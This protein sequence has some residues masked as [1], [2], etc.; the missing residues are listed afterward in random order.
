MSEKEVTTY[1]DTLSPA[2]AALWFIEN[3][4]GEQWTTAVFFYLRARIRES[5]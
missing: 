1:L 2:R 3:A 4:E 5:A